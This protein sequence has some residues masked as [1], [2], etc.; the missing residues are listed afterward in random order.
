[1]TL[2][3]TIIGRLEKGD[4]PVLA[5]VVERTGSAPRQPGAR[6]LIAG[7]LSVAGTVGGGL[8]EAEV[9][10]DVL[11]V[12]HGAPAR[13]R[14]FDMTPLAPDADMICGGTV[15]ILVE[16]LN[17]GQLVF[18]R[19]E[20][21]CR[22]KAAFGVWT[23]DITDPARPERLFHT[24]AN[25]LPDAV[26]TQVS[27]NSAGC[28]TVDGRKI[29]VEPLMHQGVVVLCGGG[30][31]S[32]ATGALAHKVGFEVIVVDDRPEFASRER[33]PF[34]RAVHELPGFHDLAATCGIGPEHYVVIVT[35]GHS[36]D[37]ECLAQA[38]RSPARYVGMIGSRRKRDGVF[39]FLRAEG[40]A[41]AEFK[42][43]HSP[44]GLDIGAE[45]PEEIAVS[46]VAEL[47]AARHG[48]QFPTG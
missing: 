34:A 40:F 9:L 17:P 21:A 12:R 36:H 26:L 38:M 30:H 7:D 44:I 25:Q 6:M 1:M 16:L 24:D 13:L 18:F 32:L 2:E 42:R 27:K 22:A 23:V 8:P 3:E 10:E 14:H 4:S 43:V 37:R 11:P 29:Y 39:S 5:T 47:V 41:E 31:V 19:Q 48:K 28:V 46:I 35:R 15:S 20:S 33:F 45:T